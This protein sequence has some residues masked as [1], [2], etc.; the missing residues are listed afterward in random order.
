MQWSAFTAK[1]EKNELAQPA[2]RFIQTTI[3]I[4]EAQLPEGLRIYISVALQKPAKFNVT[5][6]S[7]VMQ[8]SSLTEQKQKNYLAA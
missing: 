3:Q 6:D 1:G 2:F 5:I 7:R 8:R 4:R